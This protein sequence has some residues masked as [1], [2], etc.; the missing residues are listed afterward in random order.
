MES[1]WRFIRSGRDEEESVN[2]EH[3]SEEDEFLAG[4]DEVF[5]DDISFLVDGQGV[6]VRFNGQETSFSH[7]E[8]DR[9]FSDDDIASILREEKRQVVNPDHLPYNPKLGF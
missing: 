7:S 9:I 5:T 6:T 1:I 4:I 2:L 8:I 3:Q